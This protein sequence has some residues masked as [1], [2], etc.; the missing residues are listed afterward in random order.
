[1]QSLYYYFILKVYFILS[2]MSGRGCETVVRQCSQRLGTL[3]PL[4]LEFQV[5]SCE[6]PD[7][8]AG[9]Q[10]W[11]FSENSMHSYPLSHFSSSLLNFYIFGVGD[12][13]PNPVHANTQSAP[14]LHS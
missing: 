5:V 12:Q 7:R 13:I 1:M 10:T 4:K 6:L 14:E 2:Y 3:G 11:A 9:N 8:R